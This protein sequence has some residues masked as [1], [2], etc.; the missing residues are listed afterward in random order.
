M[1]LISEQVFCSIVGHGCGAGQGFGSGQ[2][3]GSGHFGSGHLSGG[4][5]AEQGGHFY[6]TSTCTFGAIQGG[7]CC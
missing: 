1:Y 2:G 7:H 4:G 6:R 3:T 5:P